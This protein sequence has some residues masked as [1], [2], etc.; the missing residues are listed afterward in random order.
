[1]VENA[2][3]EPSTIHQ[4]SFWDYWRL[5][6]DGYVVAIDSGK[7]WMR[8]IYLVQCVKSLCGFCTNHMY[9]TLY[10]H[11]YMNSISMKTCMMR[12]NG[13]ATTQKN[14]LYSTAKPAQMRISGLWNHSICDASGSLPSGPRTGWSYWKMQGMLEIIYLSLVMCQELIYW[15]DT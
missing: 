5:L 14:V 8:Y 12:G 2:M 7:W 1:M 6:Q 4:A 3:V 15:V 11:Q 13:I 9:L 10:K